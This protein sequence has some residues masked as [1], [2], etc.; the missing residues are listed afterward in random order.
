MPFAEAQKNGAKIDWRNFTPVTPTFTGTKVFEDYDLNEIAKYIDWQ[1]FFIAWEMHGKFPHILTDKIIG[2]E[3]TKL[4]NDAKNL[5]KKIM[6]EKWLVAK[7]VV[8]FWKATK[9]A[10]RYGSIYDTEGE[11]INRLEFLRQQIKKAPGQPNL[12]LAD[13]I[14]Q[15]PSPQT[16]VQAQVS[17]KA[18]SRG[19]GRK[20]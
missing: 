8:G 20:R 18:P 10:P 17:T 16:S 19:K 14:K 7:G 6:E 13:F 5:L 12:S 3:A 9:T 1:P 15:S 4:F 11:E 2:Q